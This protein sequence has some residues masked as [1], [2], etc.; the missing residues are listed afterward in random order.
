MLF[1]HFVLEAL[2]EESAKTPVF[3]VPVFESQQKKIELEKIQTMN[4]MFT[5][6]YFKES[7][8]IILPLNFSHAVTELKKLFVRRK[9]SDI[10]TDALHLAPILSNVTL[11]YRLKEEGDSMMDYF[12]KLIFYPTMTIFN[13]AAT[14]PMIGATGELL[15]NNILEFKKN[16]G[17]ICLFN[18]LAHNYDLN[19]DYANYSEGYMLR[20]LFNEKLLSTPPNSHQ[21]NIK[22]IE[23]V[24][25]FEEP[26]MRIE[27]SE[28]IAKN[29]E[30]EGIEGWPLHTC[31]FTNDRVKEGLNEWLVEYKEIGVDLKKNYIEDEDFASMAFFY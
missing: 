2:K 11:G 21:Y 30:N 18:R 5:L 23:A 28:H 17:D 1:S 27:L 6:V 10:F 13:V 25:S 26:K 9:E 19:K 22:G 15:Q 12:N 3:F 8:N 14:I 20:G 4:Q 24:V 31:L 29:Y 16:K 7:A